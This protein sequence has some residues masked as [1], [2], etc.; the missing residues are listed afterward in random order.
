M[1]ALYLSPAL[2]LGL[3]QVPSDYTSIFSVSHRNPFSAPYWSTSNYFSRL[4]MFSLSRHLKSQVGNVADTVTS[5]GASG[6]KRANELTGGVIM[7][8]TADTPVAERPKT[9]DIPKRD[10]ARGSRILSLDGGGV[11]GY[12]ALI[13]LEAFML[14]IRLHYGVEEDILPA[15]FFDLIIGTS[16]GGIMAL[17]L[18]RMRMSI[19]DCIKAYQTLSCKIF[20]GGLATTVLGGGL[21]GTGRG[22]GLGMGVVKGREL[23][24][25]FNMAMSSAIMGEPSMYDAAKMEKHVKRTIKTQPHT[26]DDEDALLEEKE[27]NNCHTT[28][29]TACQTNAVT[30]HLMRSYLRRDQPTSDNVKIWEAARATSAAPAFFA[31]IA[32]GD[33][34]VQYVDGAVSGHCNPAALAREEADSL[35]PGRENWLLLSLGT[36]APTEVSLS[37]Q[38]P[39][40]LLGFIGLSSNTIQVHEGAARTYHQ[41]YQTGHSPYIRL[42]VEHSIDTVRMDDHEKMPQVAAATTSYLS[43]EVTRQ[44]LD[45]AVELAVGV[46]PIIRRDSNRQNT[47]SSSPTLATNHQYGIMTPP[48]SPPSAQQPFIYPQPVEPKGQ[49]MVYEPSPVGI[50]CGV[51]Y[52][53][54][55]CLSPTDSPIQ[56]AQQAVPTP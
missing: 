46:T 4:Y 54:E 2:Y 19:T 1:G 34:G 21:L 52:S 38:L 22:L 44:L 31:P 6:L 41:T 20:G 26:W 47:F 11:R 9:A 5:L 32:I 42:S 39:Q 27:T 33:K 49:A 36:G 13:I 43:K 24:N 15:D 23:D 3:V 55:Q 12:S 51:P 35:W 37:G 16:T 14:R 28:I 48:Q 40:K 50:P 8:T 56:H 53:D 10:M 7:E 30:P 18:G 17:M 25:F 45:H 29:V